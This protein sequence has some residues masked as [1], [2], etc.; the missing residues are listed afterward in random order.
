MPPTRSNSN[1]S[2]PEHLITAYLHSLTLTNPNLT[3]D[4]TN[5]TLSV[6]PTPNQPSTVSVISGAAIRYSP[7]IASFVGPG[8]LTACIGCNGSQSPF[9]S[10]SAEHVRAAIQERVLTTRRVLFIIPPYGVDEIFIRNAALKAKRRDSTIQF[11]CLTAP[12]TLPLGPDREFQRPGAG[13]SPLLLKICS[14]TAARGYSLEEVLRVGKLVVKNLLSVGSNLRLDL[15]D[16]PS[17]SP[18]EPDMS[19]RVRDMVSRMLDPKLRDP[20]FVEVNSNETVLHI[21]G[22]KGLTMLEMG[23]ITSEAVKQMEHWHIRPVRI[24]TESVSELSGPGHE[25]VQDR[26]FAITILNVCNTDIGGPS[27]IQLLDAPAEAAGWTAFAKGTSWE[28]KN[29]RLWER[30]VQLVRPSGLTCK[31]EVIWRAATNG[32][33]AVVAYAKRNKLTGGYPYESWYGDDAAPARQNSHAQDIWNCA[34]GMRN[35]LL[36]KSRCSS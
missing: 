12:S 32:S 14:A 6:R 36:Q 11:E 22:H 31:A 19:S 10:D 17:S 35:L 23:A 16:G 21:S 5:K 15:Q 18:S 4:A 9:P 28:A 7:Y 33:R 30:N 25:R 3:L 29:T 13:L 8:L 20:G 26:N 24:Y 34:K 2:P 1:T 27:M